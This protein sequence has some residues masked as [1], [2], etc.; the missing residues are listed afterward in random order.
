[1]SQLETNIF[2]IRNL[3][4][5][6]S[7][8]KIYRV[9]GLIKGS[10]D[11]HKNLQL[12]SD[13]L[14]SK[15]RSP[16][17][18]FT[19]EDGTFIAQPIGYE[20]L[21]TSLNL[22]RTSVK[23]DA[24]PDVKE[25][26]FNDLNQ[27]TAPLAVKFLQGSIQGYFYNSHHLWQPRAGYPFFEKQ[28][29]QKFKEL[30]NNV[31]LFRGFTFRVV[32]LSNKRIGICIDVSSKYISRNPLPTK[33]ARE[34]SKKYQGMRCLY[35]YGNRWYEIRVE[36]LADLN[37]SEIKVPPENISLFDDVHQKVGLHKT[38]NILELPR[39]SAVLVYYNTFRDARHA[40]SGLCRQTYR[41]DHPYVQRFHSQTIKEPHHRRRDIRL[42][43][44]RYFKN[45]MFGSEKIELCEKPI[46][47]ENH[48]LAIPDLE[49]GN[50]KVLSVR[51]SPNSISTQ[52]NDFRFK[53][54]QLLYSPEAGLFT[55][56]VFDRQYIILPRSIHSSYGS[57][58]V[59]DIKNEIKAV[60]QDN[61]I[62]YE[63]SII[64]Y[65]DSVQK[66][67]VN[68]GRAIINAVEENDLSPGYGIV[69]IPELP[70]RRK[71]KEDE[72]ANL[73]MRELRKR[74]LY[75]SII[76]TTL[77][78]DSFQFLPSESQ[79]QLVSDN[80]QQSRYKGYIKNVVLNKILILNSFWPFV[81][82]TP[83]NADII[84]GIDVKNNTAGF[85]L[86]NK[87][88]A[89]ITFNFSETEQKEQLDKN[90][91][92]SKISELIINEQRIARRDIKTIVIQRQ[93]RL[94][95]QERDGVLQAL[96][97]LSD[98]GTI[99]RDFKC[100]FVEIRTTSRI[101]FRLFK[102][103]WMQ[104]DQREWIEN[105]L[106]GTFV[107]EIFGDEAFICTTGKPYEHKGTTIPLHII[108]EG[109]LTMISVL[110]DI[111][112]L[113]NLTWTKVDD[114]LRLPISIKMTDIRLRESA[115]EYDIDALK[116]GE[117]D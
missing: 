86:V 73:V 14:S 7:K 82:K 71:R 4:K 17:A 81:L 69:M 67:I 99:D 58:F 104:G 16:C 87:N 53:K 98:Q 18:A 97:I 36:S 117:E 70:S 108:K 26:R 46:I 22:I 25:L 32:P 49:F 55:K 76:H 68:I 103:D 79:W 10:D 109:P 63:P 59:D 94:F 42:T 116:F 21:P 106:V 64:S 23:I 34:D 52:L 72:L 74:N 89:E 41:T 11:Y 84:L 6:T 65:D 62:S 115:G 88:S 107:N 3:D 37:A 100:T 20:E 5:L 113:S 31:D 27:V 19:T 43:V 91:V 57:I 96:K 92:R 2:V 61:K 112:Y 13:S 40:P 56:K 77:A 24:E 44:E 110:E 29:D 90:H 83:L 78:N 111:F 54:R 75:V 101:P 85:T 66:S 95:P 15:T 102:V 105:P 114:C 45:L 60:M 93:G 39:D 28:T 8:Y 50:K 47:I 48:R 12:L 33:I 30:S 35:E 1:M 80:K 9:R 38:R 51:N